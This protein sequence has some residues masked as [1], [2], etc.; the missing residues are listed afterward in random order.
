MGCSSCGSSRRNQV[1]IQS[2]PS[3]CTEGRNTLRIFRTKFAKSLNAIK[4]NTVRKKIREEVKQIDQYLS[5]RYY[6]PPIEKLK[7]LEVKY[8]EFTNVKL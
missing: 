6:C 3:D 4:D 5:T 8:G 2:Q 7:E 1:S